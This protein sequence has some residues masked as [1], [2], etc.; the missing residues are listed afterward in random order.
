MKIS[1]VVATVNRVT[2]VEALLESLLCQVYQNFEAEIGRAL[3]ENNLLSGINYLSHK[4]IGTKLNLKE[5]IDTL[6]LLQYY[7]SLNKFIKK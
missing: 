4:L 5:K 3:K 2:E 6:G 1:L 7:Q